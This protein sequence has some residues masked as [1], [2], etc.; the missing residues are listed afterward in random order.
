MLDWLHSP[1][2]GSLAAVV[3]VGTFLVTALVYAVTMALA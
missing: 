1:T 2:L 3:F